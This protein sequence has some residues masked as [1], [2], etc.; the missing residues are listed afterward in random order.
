MAERK[1]VVLVSGQLKELPAGDTL[2]PQAPASHSHATSDVTGLDTA[3]AGK[4]PAISAGASAQYWRGDKTWRDFFTDVRAA[5]LTGLS[6]ATNAAITAADTVLSALGRLQAQITGHTGAT[7]GAHEA[8]A[9]HV[10]AATPPTSYSIP[11]GTVQGLLAANWQDVGGIIDW[12]DFHTS[13]VGTQHPASTI[14]N[15]PAGGVSAT[16]VQAAINELDAEKLSKA[17]TE[18]GSGSGNLNDAPLG[19][20]SAYWTSTGAGTNYPAPSLSVAW[21]NVLNFGVSGRRTQ[22]AQQAYATRVGQLWFR[23]LHD[24]TWYGWYRLPFTTAETGY[25][26]SDGGALGYG[27]GSGGTANQPTDKNTSLWL[28]KMCGVV[29]THNQEMVAG[30]LAVFDVLNTLSTAD[31]VAVACIDTAT[32]NY[33]E[34]TATATVSGGGRITI[35]LEKR[36]GTVNR[37]DNVVIKFALFRISST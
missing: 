24:V 12:Q 33:W 36:A 16:T 21:W 20:F 30:Q 10:A 15:T 34:Y 32:P 29:T 6:T 37:T 9:I 22:I 13:G 17:V 28:N 23:H 3:L 14:S 25:L 11:E 31:M 35:F 27:A 8:S 19:A 4:E 26:V 2:P 7:S 5:T 1:P 18:Y